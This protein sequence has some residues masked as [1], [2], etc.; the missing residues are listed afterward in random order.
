MAQI[1]DYLAGLDPEDARTIGDAY[2]VARRLV[3]DAEQGV[4]YG[5]PALIWQGKPLLAVMRAKGHYGIYPY[6]ALV[7]AA[8]LETLGPIEGLETA[9][10]TFRLPLG[11][12]IPEVVVSRLVLARRDEILVA[13]AKKPKARPRVTQDA[14]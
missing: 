5:M 13:G 7:V 1:D 8:V 3:P 9:K 2:Q 4:S 10:G 11:A 6:S 12:P 14:D